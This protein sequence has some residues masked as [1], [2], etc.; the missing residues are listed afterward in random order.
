[1]N[2]NNIS[3]NI[4]TL[5]KQNKFIAKKINFKILDDLGFFVIKNV[6]AS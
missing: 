6:F 5:I 3:K 2:K 4:K 1:M